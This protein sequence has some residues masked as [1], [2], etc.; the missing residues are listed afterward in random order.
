VGSLA[1]I[2]VLAWAY[3]AHLADGMGRMTTAMVM[4][5]AHPWNMSEILSLAVMWAVMM[6]AMMIPSATP[7]VLLF[8]GITSRRRSQGMAAVSPGVFV[9][10]Y[11]LVWIGYSA[12]AALVQ[13]GLHAAALL[14]PAMVSASP[15][16][17]GSLLI[18]AG[19]YQLLP[20]KQRCLAHCRSPLGFLVSE[21]REG[22]RG[23]LAM[24]L[25]HGSYCVGCCWLLMSL[26]FVAGVMNLVW[27]AVLS[28]VVLIERLAPGARAF[29][30]AVGILLLMAGGWILLAGR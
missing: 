30:R 13:A 20:V 27:V 25:R 17:G 10:G 22:G 23:A 4:P 5:Q 16:L 15:L 6:T 9:T 8:A 12:F 14:S 19:L 7:A 2:A 24:G 11:L 28:L 1:V 3:I 18:A 21:W 26:L 29:S